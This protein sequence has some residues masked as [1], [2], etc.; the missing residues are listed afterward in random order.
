MEWYKLRCS[1]SLIKLYSLCDINLSFVE[2]VKY[3]LAFNSIFRKILDIVNYNNRGKMWKF[4]Y[5][6]EILP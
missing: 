5:S 6:E 1:A 2:F 4:A 3:V